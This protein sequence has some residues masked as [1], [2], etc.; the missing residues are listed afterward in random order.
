MTSMQLFRQKPSGC[1]TPSANPC[2]MEPVMAE[3]GVVLLVLLLLFGLRIWYRGQILKA[4]AERRSAEA[5]EA[6][7]AALR[8]IPP[9]RAG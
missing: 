8:P 1:S 6:R 5:R 3:P 4:D 7:L 9:E 2:R